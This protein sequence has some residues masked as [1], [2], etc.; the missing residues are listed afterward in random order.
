[1]T[2]NIFNQD[3]YMKTKIFIGTKDTFFQRVK[4]KLRDK[5]SM[6]SYLKNIK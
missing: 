5:R 4:K 3:D 2:L 1:M 6:N